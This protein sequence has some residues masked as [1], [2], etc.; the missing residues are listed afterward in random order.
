M[1]IIIDRETLLAALQHLI[2]VTERRQNL[3][4]LANILVETTVDQVV[5][6]ATDMEIQLVKYLNQNVESSPGKTTF[7]A[8]KLLD[9]TRSL[10]VEARLDIHCTDTQIAIRSGKSRFTLQTLAAAEFPTLSEFETIQVIEIDGK[11]FLQL[12]EE[13]QFSMANQ[14]VRYW[15]N[16]L[17][18]EFDRLRIRAV[19]TDGHRLGL[20][21]TEG[22]T[23]VEDKRQIILPKKGVAELSKLLTETD[24]TT[25]L[26]ISNNHVQV[27]L[28]A[29]QFTSKLI[30]GRFPDYERVLAEKWDKVLTVNREAL[31]QGLLRTSILA[32]EKLKSV[33]ITLEQ[34]LL[35]LAAH[36]DGQEQAEEEIEV[37]YRGDGLE[38]GFNAAY[39]L[40]VLA[41]IKSTDVRIHLSRPDKSCLICPDNANDPRYI[42]GPIRL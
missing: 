3:P 21:E 36:T 17:M 38:I 25:R 12:I 11:K 6:I 14:D 13:T 10:P 4:I 5:M 34:N 28:A 19:A 35:R 31:K 29:Y 27:Q 16:G 39:L 1:N 7:P 32:N 2:G 40:E 15:F 22:S 26:L 42:V 20:S 24:G 33:C 9:I 18:F 23:L 30:D 8:K 41:A 37:N